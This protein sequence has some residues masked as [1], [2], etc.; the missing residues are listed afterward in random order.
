MELLCFVMRLV[1]DKCSHLSRAHAIPN[2]GDSR[3]GGSAAVA[4]L[5]GIRSPAFIIDFAESF[6]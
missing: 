1:S 4:E 3:G 6:W 2:S 5:A